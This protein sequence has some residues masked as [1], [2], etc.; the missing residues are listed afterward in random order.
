MDRMDTDEHRVLNTTR[1]RFL[2]LVAGGAA[3]I[4]LAACTSDDP[5]STTT[6]PPTSTSAGGSNGDAKEAGGTDNGGSAPKAP[7]TPATQETWLEPWVW[8]PGDWPGQ[9]LDMNVIENENPGPIVGFGNLSAVLFSYNGSTPGPTIRMKGDE[10]LLVRLRNLLP[11]DLGRTFVG[12]FPDPA[13]GARPP[14]FDASIAMSKAAARAAALGELPQPRLDFCLGEHTNGVHSVHVTNLHTHGLHVRP[15]RNP[16]GTHSDNVIL[17]LTNQ[18]DFR[19][20]EASSDQVE[21][22]FLQDSAQTGFLQRDEEV[23]HADF[24]FRIGDVQAKEMDA[25]GLP[26]Q[27]HPPGTHWYHPHAHGATHNQVAS[28]MAGFLIV[29]GDVDEALNLELTGQANPDPQTKTGWYRYIERLMF[30]QRVSPNPSLDPDS[31]PDSTLQQTKAKTRSPVFAAVNGD[32]SPRTITMR[33]GDIERWRVL[34]G[35]VDGRGYKRFMVLKGDFHVDESATGDQLRRRNEAGDYVEVNREETA[36]AKQQI[37]QLAMDGVTLVEEVGAS[38]AA[39]RIQDLS[40]QGSSDGPGD[41]DPPNPSTNPLNRPLGAMK[42]ESMLENFQACYADG[43]GVRNCYVQPNEVYMGPANRTDILF[44]APDEPG[45]YTVLAKAV[46]VH[47]DQYQTGLQANVDKDVL[48]TPPEDIVVAYVTVTDEEPSA[49]EAENRTLSTILDLNDVLPPVPPYLQPISD[50]EV[51]ITAG[52]PDFDLHPDL[53]RTRTITYSGWGSADSPLLTTVEGDPNSTQDTATTEAFRDFVEEDQKLT[54]TSLEDLRYT[55]ILQEVDGSLVSLD[56]KEYVLLPAN[57]RTMAITG[58]TSDEIIEEES[59]PKSRGRKF[60][61]TDAQRPMMLSGTAEE[62]SLHNDSISLWANTAA[63]AQPV[64]QFQG[65]YGALPLS[66][67]EGQARFNGPK[68]WRLVAKAVDHPFHIHQNPCWVMRIEVPDENGTMINI[69]DKP[70]WQDVM[71]I[72]RNTGRVVFRSRFPDYVGAYVEH[73][74]IL[75]HEDNGMMQVIEVTPFADQANYVPS[76]SVSGP[77]G[78]IDA[79]YPRH[80]LGEAWLQSMQFIDPNDSTG[81]NYPGFDLAVPVDS[82]S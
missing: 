39:Y 55:E 75:L 65:H 76:D 50:D 13:P 19:R 47:G 16:D 51:R 23:G 15:G 7:A 58:S 59:V 17:R 79:T 33:A 40:C 78:S 71:W 45:V 5:T 30:I 70:R 10:T 54:D 74:H 73:C 77:S 72:P 42:N 62:W 46:I 63:D 67:S 37:F 29:E 61:P 18:A 44:Q 43:N 64:G 38:G 31:A 26:P 12:P 2:Q 82:E 52:D 34:N 25:R 1:R 3:A 35:S 60:D 32:Q 24:A 11:Q 21:C 80:D 41:C 20:R 81:Q 9:Q 56:E 36:Q 8:R 48:K 28:G 69:L 66:R 68:G 14:G 57:L 22:G 6:S 49:A 4:P 53:Y 27:P